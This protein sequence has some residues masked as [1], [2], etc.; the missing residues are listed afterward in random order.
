V[1]PPP[2]GGGKPGGV[3]FDRLTPTPPAVP[4]ARY[5]A[6][7]DLLAVAVAMPD[8]VRTVVV[9]MT[10]VENTGGAEPE[11]GDTVER[12]ADDVRERRNRAAIARFAQ[13]Y[14]RS[15]GLA[16]TGLADVVAASRAQAAILRFPIG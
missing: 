9:L 6:L 12:A 14:G 10:E 13:A 11:L 3:L 7:P 15:E 2:S 5:G 8:A 4:T 16:V 1:L